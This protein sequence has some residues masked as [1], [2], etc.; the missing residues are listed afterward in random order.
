MSRSIDLLN[1]V[2][3]NGK[4]FIAAKYKGIPFYVESSTT[5]D[6]RK[7]KVNELPSTSQ[8]F[9]DTGRATNTISCAG[10]F[11]DYGD[12]YSA[13]DQYEIAMETWNGSEGVGELIHPYRQ[14]V[15][16]ARSGTTQATD[17]LKA[18]IVK[19]SI[20][21]YIEKTTPQEKEY[22]VYD[23]EIDTET[24]SII[25]SLNEE[26][27]EF[28]S[29]INKPQQIYNSAIDATRDVLS[30]IE[31]LKT[32]LRETAGYKDKLFQLQQNI[33]VIVLDAESL[34]NSLIDL[35]TFAPSNTVSDTVMMD[36]NFN[37]SYVQ[38]T[39]E[40]NGI[41][42]TT[43]SQ[44]QDTNNTQL[45]QLL[46]VTALTEVSKYSKTIELDSV[47]DANSLITD[48]NDAYN[49]LIN[50]TLNFDLFEKVQ[51]LQ[52]LTINNLE[53]RAKELPS[54]RV[55]ETSSTTTVFNL[56]QRF[57]GNDNSSAED[58]VERN[59][60]EHPMFIAGETEIEVLV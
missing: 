32:G 53:L 34:A 24:T 35:L 41:I 37:I 12:V 6:G 15:L 9:E 31:N 21:F 54:I 11:L 57:Y 18:G 10:Y 14:G 22:I 4:E 58:I 25:D 8:I 48:I 26:F 50:N 3:I 17:N 40:L 60:I 39:E 20:I 29:V 45:N 52:T 59:N 5:D 19:F 23:N 16:T 43:T 38:K 36:N 44:Q 49:N 42:A 7:I 2:K 33:G 28:F 1:K 46:T 55:Y 30:V 51:N 27:K 56:T 13:I 47:V